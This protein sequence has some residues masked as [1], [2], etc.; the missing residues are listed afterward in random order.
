MKAQVFQLPYLEFLILSVQFEPK[1]TFLLKHQIK[2]DG[3]QLDIDDPERTS[4][5]KLFHPGKSSFWHCCIGTYP[6]SLAIAIPLIGAFIISSILAAPL[7]GIGLACKKIALSDSKIK[8]YYIFV[9]ESTKDLKLK[10]KLDKLENSKNS[11]EVKLQGVNAKLEA[12]SA[13]VYSNE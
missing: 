1:G 4:F 11:L 2:I 3:D 10:R 13:I 5:F 7:L 9:G 6:F 12:F 8:S